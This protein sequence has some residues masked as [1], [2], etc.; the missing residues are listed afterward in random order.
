MYF[1]FRAHFWSFSEDEDLR[2]RIHQVLFN[3]LLQQIEQRCTAPKKQWDSV[4][5]ELRNQLVLKEETESIQPPD[6]LREETESELWQ[7][8]SS[9]IAN[10]STDSTHKKMRFDHLYLLLFFLGLVA[11]PD[12]ENRWVVYLHVPSS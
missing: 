4:E 3:P 8:W 10:N 12:F 2:E 9:F 5:Q 11:S 7:V 1:D 6:E